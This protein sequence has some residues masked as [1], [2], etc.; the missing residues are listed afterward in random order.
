MRLELC[1]P[2]FE[3]SSHRPGQLHPDELEDAELARPLHQQ[4]V[5]RLRAEGGVV[6]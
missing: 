2:F 1:G 5:R 3:P 4:R 6:K